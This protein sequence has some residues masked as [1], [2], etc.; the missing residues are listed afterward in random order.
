MPSK[1]DDQRKT[2]KFFIERGIQSTSDICKRTGLSKSTVNDYKK[3]L[4]EY[5][6]L[7]DL[8]RSGRP[9]KITSTLRRR[10]GQVKRHMPRAP[11]HALAKRVSELGDSPISATTTR[12]ALHQGSYHWRLPGRKKLTSFQ[13][14]ARIA[15]AEEHLADDWKH[16]WAF[17]ESYFNL[18]R[19]SNRCWVSVTTEESV[20]RSKLTD[21]QE[22]VSVGICFA[23][24]RSRKSALCF[25]P[26]NWSG[27]DLVELFTEELLP[28]I[29]WPRGPTKAQR[30]IIDN[31]GRHQMAVWKEFV[32]SRR[33]HPLSPWPSNSPDLNPI[34][35][36]FGW[37]KKFVENEG[38]TSEATLKEAVKKAFEAIPDSHLAHLMDS[39]PKRLELTL[40]AKGARINY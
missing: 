25:L 38:S 32:T 37:M 36:V 33:L 8:S 13:K 4:K 27:P 18:H 29:R 3:K 23:I 10:L 2:V 26:K 14:A 39:I 22:K 7:D 17:D 1:F 11:A 24:C 31:D 35:N 30:F 28:S 5:G 34:K 12:K 40:K 19:S 16:T 15:F 6:T 21:A 9:S 20:Q